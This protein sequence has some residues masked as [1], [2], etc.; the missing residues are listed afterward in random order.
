[1][2]RSLKHRL[3][4]FDFDGTL[5][6]TFPCFVN[7]FDESADKYGFDRLD[8][9]RQ[10]QL[11]G[12]DAR[13]IMSHHRVPLWK[14]PAISRHMRALILR[15]IGQVALFPEVGA[16]LQALATS[17]VH[18][19]IVSSNA[20]ANV[21]Q[22]LGAQNAALFSQ[23]ECGASLFGK[24][25]KVRKVLA[26]HAGSAALLVGDEIRDAKVA[27]DAGIAF[28][29]VAWGFNHLD[30]L[31]LHQPQQVFASVAEMRQKLLA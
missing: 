31:L 8:R 18:L 24:L 21:L 29:A 17:G 10:H 25:P 3:I 2:E 22:V 30:A 27:A 15:D 26:A 5:A 23:I 6:D 28:G 7:A 1:M 14:L 19:A 9:A 11:R 12:L 20:H 13:Q 16:T 4:I